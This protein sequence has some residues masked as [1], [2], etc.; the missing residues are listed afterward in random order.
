MTG[1]LVDVRFPTHSSPICHDF[2]I[3]NHQMIPAPEQ[4]SSSMGIP[5]GS[6]VP[7]MGTGIQLYTSRYLRVSRGKYVFL[8]R[9][10]THTHTHISFTHTHTA[11]THT[12]THY[13][14]LNF[15]C[16]RVTGTTPL[17]PQPPSASLLRPPWPTSMPSVINVYTSEV[18]YMLP[19]PV[20]PFTSVCSFSIPLNSG[21]QLHTHTHTRYEADEFGWQ[22]RDGY[23]GYGDCEISYNVYATPTGSPTNARL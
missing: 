12:H 10:H 9:S 14:S 18:L 20:V 16:V 7:M 4:G 8:V 21:N 6:R 11:H 15:S 2:E 19:L 17:P 5:K 3:R 1:P 22:S 23:G 13:A